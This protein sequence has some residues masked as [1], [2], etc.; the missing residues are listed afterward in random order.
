MGPRA[1]QG[2]KT[3]LRN[4]ITRDDITRDDIAKDDI[5]KVRRQICGLFAL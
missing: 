4:D 1:L 3:Q 2:K 5:I